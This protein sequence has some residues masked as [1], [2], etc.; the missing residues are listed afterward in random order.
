MTK[1]ILTFAAVILAPFI[2]VALD[3]PPT[4]QRPVADIIH[5]TVVIDPYRWLENMNA[6][7]V[8]EW[9]TSQE[10]FTHTTLKDMP[11]QKWLK[12]QFNVL[13]RYDD[14]TIPKPV[15]TGTRVF[16][17]TQKKDQNHRVYCT[18]ADKNAPEEVLIDPNTWPIGD[19]LEF[20][21][22]SRDGTYVAFGKAQGG[23]ESPIL[24]VMHVPTQKIL[25]DTVLGW[26]QYMTDWLPDGSGFYYNANPLK[27]TVPDGDETY[28]DTVY[29]HTLGTLSTEDKKI[30]SSATVKEHYN[31]V[32]ISEDGLYEIFGKGIF[33]AQEY[34]IRKTGDPNQPK[35][36]ITGFD[37]S[38]SCFIVSGKLYITTNSGAPRWKVYVTDAEKPGKENWKEFLPESNDVLESFKAID[39]VMYA[40]YSHNAYTVIKAYRPDGTFIKNVTLPAVGTAS[41]SGWWSKPG[42]KITFSALSVQST[43]YSYDLK[44]DTLTVIK[45]PGVKL[46]T[47]DLVTEQVWYTSKDGTKIP[48]F[49][50]YDKKM[51]RTGANPVFLSGY[52]GFNSPATSEFSSLKYLWVQAGGIIALP[53]IRGGSEFGEQWHI[54]GMLDKKQNV[55]DDFI[56]AAEWLIAQKYTSP[57]HLAIEGGSNGGLL[58]GAM[59]VQRPELFKAVLCEVPLLDMVRYHKFGYANIWAEE[60]GSAED[61]VQFAYILKYSP[62]HNIKEKTKYP[63]ILFSASANDARTAPLHAMKM[64]AALQKASISENPIMLLVNK[65]SGHG[66]GSTLEQQIDQFSFEYGFLMYE[67]GMQPPTK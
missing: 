23:D 12:E 61:P 14:A 41:I 58:V 11:Q 42:A 21:E 54:D 19:T 45:K 67:L 48:M 53:C 55:F 10:T 28:W 1:K 52:G 50:L 16:Y 43:T 63:A 22:P 46:D 17:Y 3:F 25:P 37:A 26:R 36:F 4:P 65:S 62:Y 5:G 33:Y 40:T 57:A 64:T 38:Y 39:G 59:M 44:N 20:A 35:A 24:Y 8:Q 6:P 31:W 56:A 30:W 60:Y 15:Y 13:W 34:Y 7:E 49:L 32:S 27:G 18:K 29:L 47:R 51:K 2:I 9:I 66:G